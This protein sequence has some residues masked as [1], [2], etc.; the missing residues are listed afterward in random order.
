VLFLAF[1]AASSSTYQ[2]SMQVVP[3]VNSGPPP[4]PYELYDA[5]IKTENWST[6][7][8]FRIL[9]NL[10]ERGAYFPPSTPVFEVIGSIHWGRFNDSEMIVNL[11]KEYWPT[12]LAKGLDLNDAMHD[13]ADNL[14]FQARYHPKS[15]A[16]VLEWGLDPLFKIG[17]ERLTA[18]QKIEQEL[19]NASK[20]F[21]ISM[22][23]LQKSVAILR[24]AEAPRLRQ[25]QKLRGAALS[26][27]HFARLRGSGQEPS[28]LRSISPEIRMSIVNQAITDGGPRTGP[29]EQ[30]HWQ[31]P[32]LSPG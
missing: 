8:R 5:L 13:G 17:P 29:P 28:I 12:L 1:G 32:W 7:D 20:R 19:A 26:S 3:N 18:S 4:A 23:E 25:L 9:R 2:R 11:F 15:V 22:T 10:L 30:R 21:D 6:F 16:Q 31:G 27:M 14:L 24:E